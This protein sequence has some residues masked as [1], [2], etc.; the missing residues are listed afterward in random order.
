MADSG[1]GTDSLSIHVAFHTI[2]MKALVWECLL[3][4]YVI[5]QSV[6]CVFVEKL[7]KDVLL[8]WQLFL[9]II[10]VAASDI[11]YSDVALSALHMSIA[12]FSVRLAIFNT[13]FMFCRLM[14]HI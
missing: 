7:E 2:C 13:D 8:N 4:L 12:S 9:F 6:S 14:C 1:I 11:I 10:K 3:P 5:G